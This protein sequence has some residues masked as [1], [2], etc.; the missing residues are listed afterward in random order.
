[1][2]HFKT[3]LILSVFVTI[4]INITKY[5]EHLEECTPSL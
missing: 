2:K 4:Q 3:K 1:M 5:Y